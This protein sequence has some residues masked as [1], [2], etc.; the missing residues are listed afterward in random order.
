MIVIG[1]SRETPTKSDHDH[2]GRRQVW[3]DE[4][5][6]LGTARPEVSES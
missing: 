3:R 1:R 5:A 4:L 2:G 6:D